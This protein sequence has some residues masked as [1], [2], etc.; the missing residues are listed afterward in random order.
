MAILVNIK[1]HVFCVG[2]GSEQHK[3]I[4]RGAAIFT[5]SKNTAA[6]FLAKSVQNWVCIVNFNLRCTI[7]N[8]LFSTGKIT[9]TTLSYSLYFYSEVSLSIW[10]M[11]FISIFTKKKQG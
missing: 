1:I 11:L 8:I 10:S 7:G 3:I 2:A 6:V 5:T 9:P 4:S